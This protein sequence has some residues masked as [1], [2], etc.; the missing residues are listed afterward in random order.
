MGVYDEKGINDY[1]IRIE[2]LYKSGIIS[3][4]KRDKLMMKEVDIPSGF[5]E[6]DLRDSQYI[7]KKAREILEELVKF[8]VPT[9]GTITD[10]LREDWQ[11]IDVMQ[12]LN[13]EKYDKLGLT[14]I[15]KDKDGR[16]IRRI[17]DWT[18][19]NDH[20]HH[21]MDALTVAFTK[22]SYIQYLNNLNARSDKSG[23][24]YAIEQKELYRD[25]HGKLRFNP[26]MPL[27]V[28]RAEA[29]RQLENTLISIKAR[30]KVLTQNVN[31]TKTKKTE[32]TR[33]R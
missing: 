11:L 7:A 31:I 1:E 12:E 4:A 22:R 23:S 6:R 17:K 24:I 3:K 14:E 30:N 18:K 29:K 33:K 19:R 9:T 27:D 26:P 25:K 20:R 13:W 2:N 16:E 5:I 10:R 28:F 15:V 21:A 8:V 32:S